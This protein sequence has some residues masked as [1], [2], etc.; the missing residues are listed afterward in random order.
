MLGNEQMAAEMAS[1]KGK[2]DSDFGHHAQ[3]AFA[4]DK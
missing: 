4:A 2:L 1:G 3:G